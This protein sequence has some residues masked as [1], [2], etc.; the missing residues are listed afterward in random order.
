MFFV[1]GAQMGSTAV[2]TVGLDAGR[3]K[4]EYRVRS[5]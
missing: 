4:V 2:C 3:Q 5:E 1:F